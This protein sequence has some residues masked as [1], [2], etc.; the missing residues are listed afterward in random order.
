MI[1]KICGIVRPADAALATE[2]GAGALG[3]LFVPSSPRYIAPGRAAGIIRGLPPHVVPVGVFA[4]AGRDEI[5]RIVDET[6][7]RTIQLH[8]TERPGE[9]DGFPVPVWKAFGVDERFRPETLG[10]YRVAAFV[11]DSVRGKQRGGTGMTFDWDVAI[12]ARRFGNII[13]AGGITP[14]NVREAASAVRPYAVDVNSGV[15]D[16]PGCKSPAKLRRL[17]E[18]VRALNH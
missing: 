5:L 4:D 9:E 17:F 15:E 13:L 2:L 16:S 8:G 1:V 18:S 10:R 12:G 14:D 6:G 11:L 7:I 3:F